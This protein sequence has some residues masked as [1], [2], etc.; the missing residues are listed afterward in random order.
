MPYISFL[1]HLILI[2]LYGCYTFCFCTFFLLHLCFIIVSVSVYNVFVL[3]IMFLG[4]ILVQAVP[5]S[6]TGTQ[7]SLTN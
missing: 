7:S 2:L 4:S 3:C 1:L 6:A 5:F